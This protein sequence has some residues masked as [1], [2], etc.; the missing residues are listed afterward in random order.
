MSALKSTILRVRIFVNFKKFHEIVGVSRKF[1]NHVQGNTLHHCP[2]RG[3][4]TA[5]GA[6]RPVGVDSRP[7]G[8]PP[9]PVG[10]TRKALVLVGVNLNIK[11]V[12][13]LVGV[14]F[15]GYNSLS[16]CT[17][18]MSNSKNLSGCTPNKSNVKNLSG[19]TPSMSNSENFSGCTPSMS[20]SKTFWVRHTRVKYNITFRGCT[21]S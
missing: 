4:K 19:C 2:D 11:Q 10:V 5:R 7:V 16:G 9:N 15:W 8:V 18:S 6:P 1:V 12:K 14:I 13:Y 17:P 20:N 21:H 3:P